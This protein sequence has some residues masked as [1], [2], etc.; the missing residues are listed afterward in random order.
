MTPR[1]TRPTRS[2]SRPAERPARGHRPGAPPAPALPLGHPAFIVA[3]MIAA[4]CVVLAA[5]FRIYD[6]DVWQHL[7]VGRAIWRLHHVP[8]T[9]LWT[10]PTYGAP[11]I[12]ASWGFRALIWPLWQAW[13]VW[14]LY[15]WRWGSAL[16]AFAVLWA[17]ARRM[18]A[19]GFTALPVVVACALVYR[20]RSQVR[21]ETLVAVL[22]ALE[23]WVLE[24]RR[25]GGRDRSA[26]LVAIAWGWANAHISYWMGLAVLGIY[27]LE[28]IAARRP[29]GRLLW[30]G[31]ASVAISFVNPWGWHALWQPFDY[32]LHGRGEAIMLSIGELRPVVWANNLKNLLP[33]LIV[34]WPALMLWRWRRRGFDLA[35][36]LMLALF[37]ALALMSQRFLGFWALVAVPYLARDFGEWAAAWRVPAALGGAWPRAAL[38]GAACVLISIPELSRVD[39]PLGVS[40][41]WKFY[42]V[43]ACDYMES[44]GVRGRG[45]NPFSAGGYM[46]YRFWPQHDRLPFMDIHQAG[47][48]EDRYLYAYAMQDSQAWHLLDRKYRF[49]YILMF[50]SDMLGDRFAGFVDADST[51]ARVFLDDGGAV[52]VRRGGPLDSLGRADAYRY[53]PVGAPALGP[54]GAACATDSVLR[55]RVRRELEREAAGSPWN[56]RASSLLANIALLDGRYDDARRLLVNLERLDPRTPR[57]NE[58]FGLI[59]L[60]EGRPREAV[61]RFRRER[62][63]VGD[64]PGLCMNEG[65]ALSLLGDRAGAVKRYRRALA[66]DPAVAAARDSLRSLGADPAP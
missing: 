2:A 59:A 55:S 1:S 17:T 14:G 32:F 42:P 52:L 46:I 26:W 19:R 3:A 41:D 61:E 24:V 4:A 33:L 58:R 65:A 49:D 56:E 39:L 7:A 51:W 27:T 48:R 30:V 54:L 38:A 16:V 36:C 63:E 57:L 13:G 47:T 25:Q 37:T 44:H 10:W 53:L 34:A 18:G 66:L 29:S 21:P 60:R 8:T 12:N 22:M 15:A 9:H 64:S 35:E 23:L 28:A 62:R 31:L 5:S 11:D 20:Q 6:T 40:F 43:R 50:R 45:F